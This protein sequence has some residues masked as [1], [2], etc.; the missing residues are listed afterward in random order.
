M[1]PLTPEEFERLVEIWETSVRATHTFLAEGAIEQ[2]RPLVRDTYLPACQVTVARGRDGI[3]QGFIGLAKGGAGGNSG[4]IEMLF[5]HPDAHGK[6]VGRSLVDFA[7]SCYAVL[8]VDVNEQNLGAVAFYARCGFKVY[9]RSPLDGQG[10]PYPL[11]HMRL[12]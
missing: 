7:K 10:N 12:G 2:F 8:L 4:K 1:T 3:I 11:L 9:G 5:V 6:G